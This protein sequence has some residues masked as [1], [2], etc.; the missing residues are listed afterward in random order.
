MDNGSRE[1]EQVIRLAFEGMQYMIRITGAATR[2]LVDLLSSLEKQKVKTSGSIRLRNLLMSGSELKVFTIQGEDKFKTFA[3]EAKEWGVLYSTIKRSAE[4]KSQEIYEVLIKAEDASKL[5]RMIEKY[6]ILANVDVVDNI[7]E[8]EN[9]EIGKVPEPSEKELENA[10]TQLLKSMHNK[11]NKHEDY[12]E[13]EW[14]IIKIAPSL[15]KNR[16][17]ENNE[18]YCMARVPGTWGDTARYLKIRESEMYDI[19]S[20]KSMYCTVIKKE[21]IYF[22]YDDSGNAVDTIN[23]KYLVNEHYWKETTENR[24]DTIMKS[25]DSKT[26]EELVREILEGLMQPSTDMVVDMNNDPGLKAVDMVSGNQSAAYSTYYRDEGLPPAERRSVVKDLERFEKEEK[27]AL[28]R[29]AEK[30]NYKG[31][32]AEL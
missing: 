12:N 23:G 10:K 15:I 20:N 3:K 4:D 5:N 1:A 28:S 2:S 11:D 22:L 19:Y 30:I 31:M 25:S 24:E 8:R 7:I 29:V 13:N 27:E 32:E 26:N 17:E 14:N 9:K 21:S 16:F 18:V 6:D